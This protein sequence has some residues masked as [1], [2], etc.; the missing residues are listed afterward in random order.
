MAMTMKYRKQEAEIEND[1]ELLE[2]EIIK[3]YKRNWLIDDRIFLLFIY[4]LPSL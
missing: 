3:V 2:R 4:F 1:I